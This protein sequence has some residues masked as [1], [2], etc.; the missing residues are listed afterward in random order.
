MPKTI[1]PWKALL[2]A[3]C[4]K[5]G[6]SESMDIVG[7]EKR[8]TKH[9]STI[10]KRKQLVGRPPCPLKKIAIKALRKLKLGE[11]GDL[12]MLKKRYRDAKDTKT[13]AKSISSDSLV[14]KINKTHV[15]ADELQSLLN[16]KVG[17]KC[18]FKGK[19][20]VLVESSGGGYRWKSC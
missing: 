17:N 18:S 8:L 4:R 15:S 3:E 6:L 10:H 11:S 19:K 13:V 14:M 1:D 9:A 5:K 16:L 20:K 7:L 2:V 12:D